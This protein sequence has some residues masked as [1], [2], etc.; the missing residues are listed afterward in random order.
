MSGPVP[1]ERKFT[2]KLHRLLIFK[3]AVPV[4]T[5]HP[6]HFVAPEMI[7]TSLEKVCVAWVSY[8]QDFVNQTTKLFEAPE[9]PWKGTERAMVSSLAAAIIRRF[10]NSLVVEEGRVPRTGKATWGRCDLWASIPDLTHA[11]TR[12]SFYLE[13]KKSDRSK[14][15]EALLAFLKSDRGLS[16]LFRDY[17]KSHRN[18][19][20]K[21]SAY[22]KLPNRV[23]EHYVIGMLVTRLKAVKKD[24]AKIEATLREVFENR[25][26]IAL[27]NRS[28]GEVQKR[29]RS[30]GRLPTVA[31]VVLPN[32]V[33]G[34]GM[35]ASFTVFGSAGELRAK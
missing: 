1:I 17:G 8:L 12:F 32:D 10:P 19:I 35:I 21:L 3:S 9:L 30:L 33:S 5:T 14:R 34:S 6:S 28:E 22:T 29:K 13:A 2:V 26:A 18:P 23:H 24:A 7:Q 31:V 20:S 16:R 27:R 25:Q 4:D 11:G 15:P